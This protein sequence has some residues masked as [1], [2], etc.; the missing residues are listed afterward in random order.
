MKK[1]KLNRAKKNNQRY[2]YITFNLFGNDKEDLIKAL[3]TSKVEYTSLAHFMRCAIN[4]ELKRIR[5]N[6]KVSES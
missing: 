3:N 6:F 4:A 1:V 5:S 2:D